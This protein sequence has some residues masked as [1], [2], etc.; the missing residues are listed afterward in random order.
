LR[1]NVRAG[2]AERAVLLDA[3]PKPRAKATHMRPIRQPPG[4]NCLTVAVACVLDLNIGDVPDLAAPNGTAVA[5][6]DRLG[7]F[8]R[9]RGLA[10]V[11][12]CLDRSAPADAVTPYS[13]GIADTPRGDRHAV[14]L[15]ER[16]EVI[17]DPGARFTATRDVTH[18]VYLVPDPF[19]AY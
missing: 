6:L 14:V 5:Q 4:A 10:A 13:I 18:A 19:A 8:L 1:C 7:T 16:Q 11:R 15:D 3:L 12:Q 9:T 2:R 17:W